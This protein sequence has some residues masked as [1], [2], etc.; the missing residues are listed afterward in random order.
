MHFEYIYLSLDDSPITDSIYKHLPIGI[1]IYNEVH[2]CTLIK[3]P[4]HHIF[5]FATAS[6]AEVLERSKKNKQFF[7]TVLCDQ[8]NVIYFIKDLLY[9]ALLNKVYACDIV[10]ELNLYVLALARYQKRKQYDV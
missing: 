1:L 6:V 10:S 4:S 2:L 3:I 5:F 9:E 8:L 7:T